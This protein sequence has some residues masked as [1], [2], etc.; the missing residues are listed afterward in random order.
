MSFVAAAVKVLKDV[1]Q[2]NAAEIGIGFVISP[3][4]A[5]SVVKYVVSVAKF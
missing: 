5:S 3:T 1:V 4:H 2:V